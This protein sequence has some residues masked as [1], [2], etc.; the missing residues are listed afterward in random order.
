[1]RVSTI[2]GVQGFGILRV[3]SIGAPLE[4]KSIGLPGF[5]GCRRFLGGLGVR[6]LGSAGLLAKTIG[7]LGSRGPVLQ[8]FPKAFIGFKS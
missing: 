3:S 2:L 7:A 4:L 8:V 1:M 6:A 5:L